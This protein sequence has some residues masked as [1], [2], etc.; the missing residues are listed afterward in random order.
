MHRLVAD[1]DVDAI[2]AAADVLHEVHVELHG[3]V[4]RELQMLLLVVAD[5]HMRGAVDE[6]VGRHQAR[7]GVEAEGG[8]LAILAGLVLELRHAVH[9]AEAGDAIE[10]PGKFRMLRHRRLIEDDMLF[11]VD[12]GGDEGG[13]DRADLARHVLVDELRRQRMQV[14]D[15]IDAVVVFLQRHELADRA[16]IVAEMEVAGRLNA[17]KYERLECSHVV[18]NRL[19][20]GPRRAIFAHVANAAAYA[21]PNAYN[22]GV[23]RRFSGRVAE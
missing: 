7:I 13:G 6:D 18:L 19:V 23:C 5:R 9:P 14:D 1:R 15:A 22:Q 11:R 4:A 2:A 17:G 21:W 16:E 3:D 10:D 20:E 8:L 12:A